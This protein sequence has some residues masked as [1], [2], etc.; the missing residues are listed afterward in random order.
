MAHGAPWIYNTWEPFERGINRDITL[1]LIKVA[2]DMG[3]DIFTIDDGWQ[4]EYGENTVDPKAFPGGLDSIREAVEARGMRLGLWIP[5]AAIGLKTPD[6]EHH[7]EWAALDQ[8]GKPKLTS[9]MGGSKVV[10]CL[11]VTV[12]GRG[13]GPNQ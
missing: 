4:Q 8:S 13:R 1:Q 3:M 12:S 5:M 10:M 9:T 6:Y 2:G 11:A 7:P